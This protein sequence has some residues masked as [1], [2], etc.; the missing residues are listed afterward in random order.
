MFPFMGETVIAAG[1]Y[2]GVD[3]TPAIAV[4]MVWVVAAAVEDAVVLG[5]TRA[6]YHPNNRKALDAG[7]PLGRLIRLETALDFV[8]LQVHPGAALHYVEAGLI[9]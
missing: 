8:A 6:I 1:S 7:H 4:G 5:L 9:R 3:D 2:R